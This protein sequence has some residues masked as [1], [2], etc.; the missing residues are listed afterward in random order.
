MRAPTFAALA[1]V[2]AAATAQTADAAPAQGRIEGRIVDKSYG[3]VPAAEVWVTERRQPLAVARTDG[4][5][6][7]QLPGLPLTEL[8]VHARAAGKVHA[9]A[10]VRLDRDAQLRAVELCL[11]DAA[12]LRGT[13]TRA[14]GTAIAGATV[15]ATPPPGSPAVPADVT[16]DA[17][18]R[19]E[20]A[21]PLGQND[22]LAFAD[23]CAAALRA[24]VVDGT[25]PCDIALDPAASVALVVQ[26]RG[27]TEAQLRR[28]ECRADL[29]LD[30]RMLD[31]PAALSRG[32]PDARGDWVVTGLPGNLQFHDQ[33]VRVPGCKTEFR[34]GGLQGQRFVAQVTA[35]EAG[36]LH[37]R[38]VDADGA[39]LG[40]RQLRC[41]TASG[42]TTLTTDADGEFSAADLLTVGEH[43]ELQPLDQA[44]ANRRADNAYVPGFD[45]DPKH[46]YAL[47][48]VAAHTITGRV[49]D[50]QG[51]PVRGAE[52]TLSAEAPGGRARRGRPLFAFATTDQ[53]GSYAFHQLDPRGLSSLR[54][55]A[56]HFDHDTASVEVV[57]A[58]AP[59]TTAPALKLTELAML[60]GVLLDANGAPVAGA[61]IELQPPEPAD[62]HNPST[63]T[64]R[65]GRFTLRCPA[66]TWR[67]GLLR[68]AS[69][70][71]MLER[72]LLQPGTTTEIELKLPR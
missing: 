39:P 1:L 23:G 65:E 21:L 55:G 56:G 6:A 46:A 2:A 34:R 66:G 32:R 16:T 10:S 13:I 20:L 29:A 48:T 44:L 25:T 38:M 45:F 27:A 31:L 40:Q 47:A 49:V 68:R 19:Y 63:S 72:V 17:Q 30:G 36:P 41:R 22:V 28:A 3:P 24:V 69:T 11:H 64:D 33:H 67:P 5:G 8:E 43:F 4:S 57:L 58:D 52:V 15:V 18:G 37:G 42:D 59:T 9:R 12:A 60:R 7:F 71:W 35:T 50:G 53:N 54:V 14:D 62:R 61:R 51:Q 70:T 26:I